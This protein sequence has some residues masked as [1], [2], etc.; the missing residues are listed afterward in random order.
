MPFDGLPASLP[1]ETRR[2]L[3]SLDR[4]MA[5]IDAPK[6]WCKRAHIDHAGRRCIRGALRQTP[7]ALDLE[8]LVAGV[9]REAWIAALTDFPDPL[10][11]AGF[12]DHPKTSH[13][14]VMRVLAAARLRLL[15]IGAPPA[16]AA[17]S[18][19]QR[20]RARRG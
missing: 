18:L 12:N 9:I 6:K 11:I 1:A 16:P 15:G 14:D 19:W 17:L 4:A 2:R 5:L 20:L 13:A 8:H 7:A 10:L 3:A